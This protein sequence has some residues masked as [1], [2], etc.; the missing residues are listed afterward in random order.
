MSSRI[1]WKIS[2]GLVFFARA[3]APRGQLVYT[4]ALLCSLEMFPWEYQPRGRHGSS[5]TA[6]TYTPGHTGQLSH[7]CDGRYNHRE[8][9]R[10]IVAKPIGH[11]VRQR[12][13]P[14]WHVELTVT[15]LARRTFGNIKL[16]ASDEEPCRKDCYAEREM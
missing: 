8:H 11:S 6:S 5:A 2:R 15:L 9:N 12:W 4:L 10:A 3:L 16:I 14:R 7:R 1:R 13:P